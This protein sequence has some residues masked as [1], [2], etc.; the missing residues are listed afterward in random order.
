MTC[1]NLKT[2]RGMGSGKEEW[3][4]GIDLVLGVVV[5]SKIC[6]QQQQQQQEFASDWGSD[7]ELAP[8]ISM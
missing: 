2:K 3:I 7:L 5:M 6:I 4:Y 1:R 8:D